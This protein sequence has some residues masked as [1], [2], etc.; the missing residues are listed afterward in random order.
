M[1][2]HRNQNPFS[3]HRGR[4]SELAR[5][6]THVIHPRILGYHAPKYLDVHVLNPFIILFQRMNVNTAEKAIKAFRRIDVDSSAHFLVPNPGFLMK[7]IPTWKLSVKDWD[8]EEF[9]TQVAQLFDQ[10]NEVVL[11]WGA[12]L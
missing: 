8:N 4:M 10:L 11:R 7:K 1:K 2:T 3:R 6:Q 12:D 5:L 9:K